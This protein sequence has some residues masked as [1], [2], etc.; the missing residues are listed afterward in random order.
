MFVETLEKIRSQE[1]HAKII[2]FMQWE[3]LRIQ[4]SMVLADVGIRHLSLEGDIFD[5]TRALQ[6]FQ[7]DAGISILLLS[8]EHSASGTNLTV[9]SHVFLMHPM[10][11]ACQE[12]VSSYEAQAIGRVVR[13]GQNRPVHVWRFVT[14]NTVEERLWSIRETEPSTP[15][16]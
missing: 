6:N 4:T 8:L 13:L 1:P 10:L 9:A 3:V 5:R 2:V 15:A 11:A 7:S 16:A 12:E 14:S